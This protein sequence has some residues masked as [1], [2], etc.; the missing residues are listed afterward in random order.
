MPLA[1]ETLRTQLLPL[2]QSGSHRRADSSSFWCLLCL[3]AFCV[4]RSLRS[5]SLLLRYPHMHMHHGRCVPLGTGLRLAGLLLLVFPHQRHVI[6]ME[7]DTHYPTATQPV[8]WSLH[9]TSVQ[10]QNKQANTLTHMRTVTPT[11]FEC[12][13]VRLSFTLFF[14]LESQSHCGLYCLSFSKDKPF[15]FS[16]SFPF[17]LSA[18]VSKT[19]PLY[20]PS[21]KFSNKHSL[22]SLLLRVNFQKYAV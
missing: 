22:V 10:K 9:P 12:L 13:S 20:F 8:R 4:S 11:F 21:I 18:T 17:F 3:I 14:P 2:L 6:L 19:F 7:P 16:V 15:S 5:L 1:E